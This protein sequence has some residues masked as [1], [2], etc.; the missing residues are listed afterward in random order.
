MDRIDSWLQAYST[1]SEE[2][3]QIALERLIDVSSPKN[4]RFM[5]DGKFSS[6]DE[7]KNLGSFYNLI[8]III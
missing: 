6:S 8:S 3:Q 4:I 2:E 1:F 7:P 5:R